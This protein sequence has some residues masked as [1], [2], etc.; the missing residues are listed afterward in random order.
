MDNTYLNVKINMLYFLITALFLFVLSVAFNFGILTL[1]AGGIAIF[2][3]VYR[4]ILT[5]KP[6][7]KVQIS[8]PFNEKIEQET[9]EEE[10][11][12]RYEEMKEKTMNIPEEL[13]RDTSDDVDEELD[14]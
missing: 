7:K 6:V 4:Y 9:Q 2:S 1:I 8:Q 11:G 13:E 5:K 3:V 14:D 12:Q 10:E